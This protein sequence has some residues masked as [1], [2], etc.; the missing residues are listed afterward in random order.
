MKT[1][2][3]VTFAGQ[4]L[5]LLPQKAVWWSSQSMLLLS[6]VHLG[7]GE[8]F[9]RQGLAIPSG[10]SAYDMDRIGEL[11]D[12]FDPDQVAILGDLVHGKPGEQL[13]EDFTLWRSKF[14]KVQ[15][16]LV[17]GNHD[18]H[19]A[20][21]PPEWQLAVV[22]ATICCD[23][24]LA[25]APGEETNTPEIV[26]HIH[27]AI[28]MRAGRADSLRAPAFW[29]QPNRLVLPSFGSFTG[30]YTVRPTKGDR[31]FAVGPDSVIEVS[32]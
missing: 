6:D 22:P 30:G 24:L 2:V 4:E 19:M 7:K 14:K 20:I 13:I 25:H 16:Q 1:G 31:L 8:V 11:I 29:M 10:D 17:A 21:V 15:M 3:N 26:G 28:R 18:R 12:Q 27:P 5:M 23:V 32:S 9:R